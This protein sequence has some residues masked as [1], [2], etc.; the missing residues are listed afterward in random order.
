MTSVGFQ[1]NWLPVWVAGKPC[2][3]VEYPVEYQGHGVSS[4]TMSARIGWLRLGILSTILAASG[5]SGGS[6]GGSAA[7]NSSGTTGSSTTGSGTTNQIQPA[8]LTMYGSSAN[9]GDVAVGNSI[10]VGITFTN[11]GSG[12]LTLQQN[13]VSGAGFTT[14]GIGQGMALN[15]GQNVTLALSFEPSVTGRATGMVSLTSSTSNA[16]ITLALSGNGV[17]ATHSATV[18][19]DASKSS[20]VG[21]NIY[22]TPA[23]FESWSK[24][25]SSP[26][27]ANSYTDWDVQGGGSYLYTVT[28]VS[29][30]NVE[31]AFS[32]AT[33]STIPSP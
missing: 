4:V 20:V 6:G 31:S 26:V 9:F 15:A 1:A 19:W 30:A 11:S 8:I 18:N 5:C 10:T 17:S 32:D 22:R 28:S 29:P 14:S 27:I 7:T 23:A 16:P 25:N 3:T 24:L 33:L 12:P 2:P 13:S 21:Y